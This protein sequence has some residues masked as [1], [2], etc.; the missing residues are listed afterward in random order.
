MKVTLDTKVNANLCKWRSFKEYD[1]DGGCLIISTSGS[2][3]KDS[4]HALVTCKKGDKVCVSAEVKG[5]G[6]IV[7]YFMYQDSP[8]PPIKISGAVAAGT[9][10]NGVISLTLTENYKKFFVVYEAKRD[11]VGKDYWDSTFFRVSAG[12]ELEVR[13]YKIE[14]SDHPTDYVDYQGG[15]NP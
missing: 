11:Y 15:G 9:G 7:M 5:T 3:S 8:N 14:L 1:K 2:S 10:T 4:T 13:N 6:T 12:N